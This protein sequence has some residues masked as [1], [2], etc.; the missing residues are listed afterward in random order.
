[1]GHIPE[2][3]EPPCS[4]AR[5]LNI[6]DGCF[7]NQPQESSGIIAGER[8]EEAGTG[9]HQVSERRPRRSTASSPKPALSA[10]VSLAGLR[11][12][13]RPNT[14]GSLSGNW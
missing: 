5:P 8:R 1:M 3:P 13:S 14:Q 7:A 9:S 10:Q 4:M 11:P 2:N 12:P 6:C